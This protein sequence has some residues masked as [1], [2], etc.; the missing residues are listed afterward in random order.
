VFRE[1]AHNFF[2]S[3]RDVMRLGRQTMTLSD[4]LINHAAG[5]EP[6]NLKGRKAI[7]QAHCHHKSVLGFD[8]DRELL[9]RTGLEFEVLNSGCCGM[10]GAF[11]FERRHY[12][13]SMK[14]GERLLLP[15]VRSAPPES[16]HSQMASVAARRSSRARDG[17]PCT[18]RNYWPIVMQ[19]VPL[20]Y[21]MNSHERGYSRGRRK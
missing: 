1:E 6:P 11:G 4:F 8:T 20:E 12:Q 21:R 10:A 9:A 19:R 2:S 14:I 3:D 7:V 18:S 16:L 13:L 15:A 5:Y 17:R